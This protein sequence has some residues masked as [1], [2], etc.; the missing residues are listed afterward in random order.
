M[1]TQDDLAKGLSRDIFQASLDEGVIRERND[2]IDE[3]QR[4]VI[5]D[6]GL[7]S[8]YKV[9]ALLK[10]CIHGTLDPESKSPASLII[11]DYQLEAMNEGSVFTSVTTS[12][13]FS[14]YTGSDRGSDDK[15]V[16]PAVLAYAPFQCLTKINQSTATARRQ[17]NQEAEINPQVDGFSVGSIRFG[18]ESESTH[19][20]R[21]FERGR[22][23]RHFDH[24]RAHNVWWNLVCN[25]SQA[26]SITPKFRIA[27]LIQRSSDSKFQA[28][29]KISARGGFGYRIQELKDRWLYRTAIDDHIIFDPSNKSVVG[30]LE[31]VDPS[32][33]GLLRKRERMEALTVLPGLE[34]IAE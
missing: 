18:R 9:Q 12:Y 29:F 2:P 30:D 8:P 11:V 15:P 34:S 16:S 20:Q 10:A 1:L 17:H 6:R 32:S 33:L 13:T 22:A 5:T 19:E 21:Y 3:V 27:M 23:G 26:L 25:E 28:E 31:G 24:G 14:E 4:S 7:T